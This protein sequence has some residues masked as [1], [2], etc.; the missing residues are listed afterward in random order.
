[1]TGRSVTIIDVARH[2]GVSKTTASDALSGT[3]RVSD[4]T[5]A[6]IRAAAADLGYIPNSAARYLRRS[7]VGAIGLYI[8]HRVMGMTFYMDFA[9]GA[10]ERALT[11]NFNLTL[12]APDPRAGQGPQL[13]VDGLIII[14]PLPGDLMTASLLASNVPV[15]TVGRRRDAGPAPAGVLHA[16]PTAL[17]NRLL[18][19]LDSCGASAP[20]LIA[21]DADFRADWA[22]LLLDAYEQWCQR[23]GLALHVRT[24]ATDATP[25]DVDRAVQE[26]IG[27]EPATDALVCAPDGAALRALGTLRALGRHVGEDLLLASCVDSPSLELCHPPVTAINLRPRQYGREAVDLLTG[28]LAGTVEPGTER[29]HTADLLV[30]ASTNGA[31]RRAPPQ[32]CPEVHP[33][34][35]A[36]RSKTR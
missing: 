4:A 21:N 14:D 36:S 31:V 1:M 7:K 23:R 35:S 20:G 9:F 29:I 27:Q 22:V 6:R 3:G 5:R 15:V 18:G 10:A 26:L 30:R 28:I 17:L 8:P 19:H 2:A 11:S 12:L 33:L 34:P 24:I 16:D 32:R 25:D 13:R